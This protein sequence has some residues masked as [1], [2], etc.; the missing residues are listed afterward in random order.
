[1]RRMI[2]RLLVFS[3]VG[4]VARAEPSTLPARREQGALVFDGLPE[5]PK[6]VTVRLSQYLNVRGASFADWTGDGAMLVSTRF[7]DTTQVHR[8]GGPREYRQQLTFFDEPVRGVMTDPA[9]P[10]RLLLSMDAGGG[11]FYQLHRLD[12]ATGRTT[13]L[14]DGASRNEGARFSRKGD[15][16]AYVST[17]RNKADFD[18]WVQSIQ[19]PASAT[20]ECELAGQW[21]PLDWSPDDRRLLLLHYVSINDSYLHVYDFAT[22][23]LTEL[24]PHPGKV[25]SF[26]AAAF[27]A[28]GSV[29]ATSDEE[30]E[31]LR[32]VRLDP[33]QPEKK[34]EPFGAP[35]SWDVTDL[36]VSA[37]GKRLAY[38]VNEGGATGLYL[39]RTSE[40]AKARRVPLDKG[41]IGAMRF[42]A[43]GKRLGF[44]FNGA[45][46]P[47]DAWVADTDSL[48]VTRWTFS[49]V[50]GLDAAKFV[51]PELVEFESFDGRKI[52]SW[53]YRPKAATGPLPVI[54]QIHGGPEAQSQATFSSVA[55]YWVNELGA[56]VL[57]PNVRG[58]SGYGKSYLRLDNGAKRE[59]SVKDIGALLDWVAKRPELDASRVAVIG[60]SYGGYMSLAS[61]T[62]YSDRLRCGV[63]VV[64]IS[65]FV[66]FLEHTE[67]YRRD[68][69]RA[70]YGDERD[71]EL[72]ALLDRISP[73][74]NAASIRKPLFVVQGANDPR[75]PASEAEQ[76]VK[77]V[78]EGGGAVWYLLAKDEGHGFSKKKNRDAYLAATSLFFETHLLNQ[79]AP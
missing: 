42:D 57:M 5:T 37:D 65:H 23:K 3:L 54:I 71:P 24:R 58:S 64:G 48:K 33:S 62:R 6:A 51:S 27:L 66:T 25:I 68:L 46:A 15:R 59:D 2:R 79:N 60:G 76:I 11:E 18:L 16:F 21:T 32:L 20:L 22:K 26:G 67:A 75:V 7:G 4:L 1:M 34:P 31:F 41:V 56:A 36:R 47:D 50:G 30:A 14:T 40:P 77:T 9:D 29:L 44:S 70:E 28:D 45:S 61:L 35:V 12:L 53:Y 72:R 49:E 73:L 38:A 78:R 74:T 39:G 63:D 10:K 69:R 55:Q 8:V 19:D 17:R 52:P 43:S 13:L